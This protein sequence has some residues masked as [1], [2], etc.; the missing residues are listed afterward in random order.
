M[1]FNSILTFFYIFGFSFKGGS[2]IDSSIIVAIYL[3]IYMLFHKSYTN[4]IFNFVKSVYF[5]NIILVY[6]SINFWILITLLLNGSSDF[7]YV[8]TFMHMF[9]LIFV[10]FLLYLYF[11][12]KGSDTQIVNYIIISFVVQS[13]IE[14]CAFIS[15][16]FKSIINITKSTSTIARGI[17][18]GGVRANALSGSDFF[19]LSAAYAVVFIIFLS[20][21]NTLFRKNRVLSIFLYIVI[22]SGTFFAGRTGYVGLGIAFIYVFIRGLVRHKKGKIRFAEF[23]M[24]ILSFFVG[25]YA[26]L[27]FIDRFTK[28]EK[29]YNLFHFTFQSLFNMVDNGSLMTSSTESLQNMYFKIPFL[30]FFVGDGRYTSPSGGYYMNTDVGYMRV[31]LFMGIIGFLL[32]LYLQLLILKLSNSK[33]ML[34]KILLLVCLLILN[35]KGEVIVW[36]QIVI[37]VVTLYSIQDI[38]SKKGREYARVDGINDNV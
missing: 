5:R 15:P 16:G 14:W 35:L 32:L 8:K 22:I 29:F 6:L 27:F 28:D 7:S 34:L 1:I 2:G 30:T 37:G 23:V 10:G 17:S 24:G 12:R 25:S 20:K 18:Y 38:F 26:L 36:N 19:G 31:I 11:Y 13:I 9:A 4:L 21:Y 33:E 3:C